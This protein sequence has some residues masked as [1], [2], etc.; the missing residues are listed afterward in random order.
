MLD[1]PKSKV[2]NWRNLRLQPKSALLRFPA[3]HRADLERQQR[4]DLTRSQGR[5]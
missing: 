5:R 2:G 3:V 1:P 4:V